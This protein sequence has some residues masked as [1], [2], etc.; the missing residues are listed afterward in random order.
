MAAAKKRRPDEDALSGR[1]GCGWA[2]NDFLTLFCLDFW[3]TLALCTQHLDV[4][5]ATTLNWT[6]KASTATHVTWSIGLSCRLEL[7]EAVA[8][9]GVLS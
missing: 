9:D 3:M 4:Q 8:G 1:M 7:L 2:W 6:D 5:L